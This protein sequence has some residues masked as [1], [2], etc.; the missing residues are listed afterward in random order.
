[1]MDFMELRSE[2]TRFLNE[3]QYLSG[4]REITFNFCFLNVSDNQPVTE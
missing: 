2:T 4:G 1:M 3:F